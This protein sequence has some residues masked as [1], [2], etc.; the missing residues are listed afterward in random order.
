M[1]KHDAREL[2]EIEPLEVVKRVVGSF[3]PGKHKPLLAAP[4]L[5]GPT[6]AACTLPQVSFAIKILFHMVILLLLIVIKIRSF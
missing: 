6:V 5:Y 4:D 2:Y 1:Y 3:V